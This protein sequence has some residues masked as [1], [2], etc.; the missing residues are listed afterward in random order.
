MGS[1][2]GSIVTVLGLVGGA[3]GGETPRVADSS[4]ANAGRV[5]HNTGPWGA[6]AGRHEKKRRALCVL[7]V[8][9]L[10]PSPAAPP[11][12]RGDLCACHSSGTY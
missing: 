11:G 2:R 4:A 7:R 8:Q 1:L 12:R 9:D 10:A 6:C 3:L 5:N